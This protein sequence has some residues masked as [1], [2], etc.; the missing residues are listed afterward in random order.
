MRDRRPATSVET[1]Q[2][3][4][5]VWR[6]GRIRGPLVE[7]SNGRERQAEEAAGRGDARQLHAKGSQAK[8]GD[9][10]C[11]AAGCQ[12][13]APSHV[14]A[15]GWAGPSLFAMVLFEKFG[16]HQ[17]LNRQAERSAKEGVPISLSS[18]ADQVGGCAVALTP[19]FQRLEAHVLRADC[20]HGDGCLP[21]SSTLDAENW[22]TGSRPWPQFRFFGGV[23]RL[24]GL[25]QS[26]FRR[27]SNGVGMHPA[28]PR[29]P[30]DMAK[31]KP[32]AVLLRLYILGR[33]RR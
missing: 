9:A 8:N 31:L 23:P 12:A 18:L 22:R 24:V 20:L 3:E 32:A 7:G 2:V 5:Q 26:K 10:R 4:G 11:E 16:Q 21:S 27:L 25:P 29:K 19:L 17:P 28:R 1:L 15:R 6:A 30:R 14:I 13:P 33:L